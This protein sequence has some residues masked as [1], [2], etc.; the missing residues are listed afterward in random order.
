MALLAMREDISRGN[1]SEVSRLL[2]H[3]R[4]YCT[5]YTNSSRRGELYRK[6]CK[7]LVKLSN[8]MDLLTK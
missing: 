2:Q 6:C 5:G 3:E 4:P 1:I 7:W 8:F